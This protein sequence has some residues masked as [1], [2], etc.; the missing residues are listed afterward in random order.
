MH[1]WPSIRESEKHS[2]P[3]VWTKPADEV[4]VSYLAT[5]H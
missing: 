1:G 5:E 3:I 2:Q 4:L